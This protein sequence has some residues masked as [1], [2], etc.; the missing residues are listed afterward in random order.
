M[1][2]LQE[3]KK[4]IENIDITYDYE[5]TYNQLYNTVI[6]YEN[7]TQ[8]WDFEYIF[9]DIIDYDTAEEIAKQELENGGLVRLYYFL[10]NA[11]LNNELFKINGYENLEDVTNDDLEYIKNEILDNIERLE[12]EVNE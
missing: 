8:T 7:D 1:K 3:L 12:S 11:N 6:D 10:G 5:E 9:E 4:E 2:T